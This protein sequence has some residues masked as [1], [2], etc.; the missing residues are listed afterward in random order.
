MPSIV[1]NAPLRHFIPTPEFI[2][3]DVAPRYNYVDG[4]RTDSIIG[5]SYRLVNVESYDLITVLVE[6]TKPVITVDDLRT[7]NEAGEKVVVEIS[8]ATVTPY[9]SVRTKSVE[10]SI[11]AT[12]I[13]IIKG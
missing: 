2:V 4:K 1:K 6:G 8:G 7:I 3:K 13:K 10:D 11:K 12:G 9:Y 5:H